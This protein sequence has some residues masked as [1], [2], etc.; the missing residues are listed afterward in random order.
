[1]VPAGDGHVPGGELPHEPVAVV[2]GELPGHPGV[3]RLDGPRELLVESE[4][5]RRALD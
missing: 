2:W 4:V 1:M 5:E 3:V